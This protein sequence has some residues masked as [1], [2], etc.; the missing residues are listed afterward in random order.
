MKR[1][2]ILTF[3]N[4]CNFGAVLQAYALRKTVAEI[5]NTQVDIVNYQNPRVKAESSL[6]GNLNAAQNK[7]KELLRTGLCF[8]YRVRRN[9]KFAQFRR[10]R[11][12]VSGKAVEKS[13]LR[14]GEY[15]SY[16]VGSDQVWNMDLTG[17][18]TTFFLDFASEKQKCYSYGASIGAEVSE[19]EQ[20]DLAKLMQ[21]FD[22]ISFRE[23]EL[24]PIFS[25]Q[26]PDKTIEAVLD[27]VFL[28]PVAQ[29]RKLKTRT[30]R[31]PYLLFF[32]VGSDSGIMPTMEFAMRLAEE[33]GLEPLF[34]SDQDIWYKFRMMKHYGAASP[35]E[36]L[37]LID[38]ADCIVTNSFHATAFSLLFHK[39]LYVETGIKRSSRILN[40]L[41]I[42]G[43]EQCALNKGVP[44]VE[45]RMPTDWTYVDDAL[46][47]KRELS[48][49]YIRNNFN[50]E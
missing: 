38:N 10:N 11:L 43:Q 24:V 49:A 17:G 23:D 16:I 47:R 12:R 36:Y 44:V 41:R 22:A 50:E 32:M 6:L 45:K 37:A 29:W 26:I 15:G 33:K 28:L 35:E 5:C 9:C 14:D 31:K 40:L 2:G 8:P 27:P 39:E 30:K 25:S 34:L 4:A 7:G 13:A 18:D 3:H 19:K 21:R 20:E 42:T 1:I 46:A 48:L